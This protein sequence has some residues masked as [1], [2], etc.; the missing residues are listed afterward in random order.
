MFLY[1]SPQ[2]CVCSTMFFIPTTMCLL[3]HVSLSFPTT[4]CLLYHVSV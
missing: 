4:M 1:N 3:Y 2:Q